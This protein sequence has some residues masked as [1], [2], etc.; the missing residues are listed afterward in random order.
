MNKK[1]WYILGSSGLI[2]LL[3]ILVPFFV[4]AHNEESQITLIKFKN[5]SAR[6]D[7][8]K[9]YPDAKA[10]SIDKIV[11]LGKVSFLEDK[12]L[13]LKNVFDN[14]IEYIETGQRI[15][16]NLTPN[17]SY[18]SN[19]WGLNKIKAANA[20]NVS[21]GDSN[22]IIAII[23]TG[24]QLDHP[25]LVDKIRQNPI[26][27][28]GV[29]GVDD[30]ANGLIDDINGWDWVTCEAYIPDT[31]NC[32]PGKSK[33]EDNNPTD[34]HGHGTV[35]AGIAAASTN[36]GQGI[37][38]VAWQ[39]KIMALRVLNQEGEG[40]ADDVALAIRYAAD[41]GAKVINLSLGTPTDWTEMRNAVSY[42]YGQGSVLVAATGNDGASS[43]DYPARYNHVIG[44][45]SINSAGQL[46]SFTNRGTGLDIAAPGESIRSTF[47]GSSY[48]VT[49]GGTSLAS[50]FVAGA[51]SL[52]LSVQPNLTADQVEAK[53]KS[54]GDAV[55]GYNLKYLNL[56]RVLQIRLIKTASSG[57]YVVDGSNKFALWNTSTF[58]QR[59]G[60]SSSFVETVSQGTF[61]SYLAKGWFSGLLT[62]GS[63][64]YYV[65]NK[66]KFRV[67]PS[68][69]FYTR[70][71]FSSANRK[72]VSNS[73]LAQF[74]LQGWLSGLIKSSS[75]GQVYF[76]DRGRKYPV[77]RTTAF[78]NRFNFH[79]SDIVTI[80]Q[81]QINTIP[82]APKLTGLIRGETKGMVYLVDQGVGRPIMSM[83]IFYHWGW[84]SS[85]VSFLSDA[86]I[87]SFT[88]NSFITR[89][90]YDGNNY[91]WI[92]NGLKHRITNLDFVL[93]NH[94]WSSADIGFVS[95]LFMN[96]FPSGD[97]LSN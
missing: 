81:A 49:G 16:V 8:L 4:S 51:A 27:L 60:F 17:D 69:V 53:I 37:A 86:F 26:E 88:K 1:S 79:S 84:K 14:E 40:W 85:E 78:F 3:L 41:Q 24:V 46:S 59:F 12:W 44:V 77:W 5:D 20:W 32:Q 50:P 22:Q 29:P 42:A 97:D 80:S 6:V 72:T 87:N 31:P 66:Q 63:S 34:D 83:G 30:D 15:K 7:F 95:A 55:S 71:G 47:L 54:L 43:V 93:D 68:S 52:L 70:W 45:G 9:K 13:K 64:T 35:V 62:N 25:D 90:V 36:N 39:A 2:F 76:I 11:R 75:S 96:P 82:T 56:W 23:D 91:Y 18:Y 89:L 58:L 74:P 28:A 94:G 61:D 21:T 73:L 10:S 92:N 38:G 48:D 19:Q 33:V 57:L 65:D 67:W